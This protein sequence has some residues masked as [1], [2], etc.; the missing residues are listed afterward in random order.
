MKKNNDLLFLQFSF[1]DFFEQQKSV[2][3][4]ITI[5]GVPPSFEIHDHH[6]KIWSQSYNR[7]RSQ[8]DLTSLQFRYSASL[9]FSS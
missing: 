2:G 6:V 9:D 1:G 3:D 7:K 8:K 4:K 5:F